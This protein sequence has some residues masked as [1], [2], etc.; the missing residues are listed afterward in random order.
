MRPLGRLGPLHARTR[1]SPAFVFDMMEPERTR[2]DLVKVRVFDP[3]DFV[4]RADGDCRLNPEIA[5]M[6]AAKVSLGA[7]GH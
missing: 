3:G 7:Y 1:R 5:R 6:V 2:L 4:I